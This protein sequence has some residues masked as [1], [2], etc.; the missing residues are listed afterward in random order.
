MKKLSL[1]E[2]V[3]NPAPAPK[4][5]SPGQWAHIENPFQRRAHE[6]LDFGDRPIP[7]GMET[8]ITLVR[9][10]SWLNELSHDAI[11]AYWQRNPQ[12]GLGIIVDDRTMVLDADSPESLARLQAL[13]S[14]HGLECNWIQKTSKGM[15]YRFRRAPNT[16]AWQQGFST[17]KSP[18]SIDV[19]TGRSA[20]DGLA[21]VVVAPSPGKTMQVDSAAR[22]YELVEVGQE[23]IDAV[24][25]SNG[26]EAPRPAAPRRPR[27]PPHD[28]GLLGE[29]LACIK[30]DCD[31]DRWLAVLMALHFETGGSA[32]GLELACQWSAGDDSEV[33]E[34]WRSFRVD[35]INPVGLGT[36]KKYATEEGWSE[37]KSLLAR[38][39]KLAKDAEPE[40]VTMLAVQAGFLGAVERDAVLKQIKKSTGT[41]MGALRSAI[42][43]TKVGGDHLQLARNAIEKV[44]HKNLVGAHS[45][46]WQ[47]SQ[48]GVWQLCEER[49][50]RQLV[51]AEVEASAENVTKGLVDSVTDLL[52]TEV[53]NQ[54]CT[55]NVGPPECVN[56]LNGELSLQN[57]E[58]HIE[59]HNREH[60]RTSQLPVE[61]DSEAIAPRFELFL[62][63]VFDGDEDASDKATALLEMMGYSLMAHCRQE[64]FVLLIGEGG[65]GKSVVLRV[66]EG[67]CGPDAVAAVQPASF[68]S[69]FQRAELHNKL[70][71]L[72]SEMK[73]GMT[74]DDAALKAIVSGEGMT[75][76]HKHQKPFTM[77][78]FATCWFGANHLPHTRDFS[79][80]MFRRALI[81]RFN[82]RFK[83]ELGNCDPLL[84]DK[85]MKELP[86]IL[87]L[88][89]RAYASGLENGFTTPVN[90]LAEL[91]AWRIAADQ[92]ARFVVES[93]MV[94]R[95]PL[96]R[97]ESA[98]LY[99]LYEV[100]VIQE[101]IKAAV[102]HT[103][104]T[105]RLIQLGCTTAK[106]HAGRRDICGLR[107]KP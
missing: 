35:A 8:K 62:E 15:H 25:Q 36:L 86:G 95:D 28:T 67:L 56:V 55:F 30:P 102:A 89:L 17:I 10:N 60:Y 4:A 66:I 68:G 65:N 29:L 44:G 85:L 93:G 31:Y 72:V 63:S 83:P 82:N 16:T 101:N 71:N 26:R 104:F 96:G 69:S 58:W 70:V 51:Q 75:V 94:E 6:L 32:D 42:R 61:F 48:R 100:W 78:P 49:A 77:H 9:W 105:E 88:A 38:A 18:G 11:D 98:A 47:W 92:V 13:I 53:Y 14:E 3:S 12:T 99:H 81:L 19:K 1:N 106:G 107:I 46:V 7:V 33:E 23:F 2:P 34:K 97:T 5:G 76:E 40:E 64:K 41:P 22:V 50:L 21:M 103:T 57:G 91:K 59:P 54:S 24:W 27:G 84:S 90:S 80:G 37:F 39:K 43:S 45:G 87:N 52:K 20:I 73:Q 74:I 79:D